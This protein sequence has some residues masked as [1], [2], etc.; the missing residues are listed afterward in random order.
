MPFGLASSPERRPKSYETAQ[1]N[2]ET[3]AEKATTTDKAIQTTGI[4]PYFKAG[5]PVVSVIFSSWSN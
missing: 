5:H 3:F 2:H 1:A 4:P